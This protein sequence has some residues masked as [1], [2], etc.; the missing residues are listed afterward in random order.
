MAIRLIFKKEDRY[1]LKNYRPVSLISVDMKIITEALAK[2]IGKVLP[3]II[4]KNQTCIPGRNISCNIHNL[5]DIQNTKNIQAVIL[6]LDQE[7]AF[8]RV[9]HDFLIKTLNHFNFGEYFTNWVKIMLKDI[10]S[11]IK[12]NGFLF[13]KKL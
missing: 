10:T 7:K 6:F 8:D 13:L 9:N 1:N 3:S 5:I 12:I 11:Q 4:Y 2:R